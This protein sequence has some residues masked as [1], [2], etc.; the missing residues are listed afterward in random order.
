MKFR[1][2]LIGIA[3]MCLGLASLPSAQEDPRVAD[4]ADT[5]VWEPVPVVVTPGTGAAPPSDAIVLFDGSDLNRWQHRD[6]SDVRWS[7]ADGAVTVMPGS[8][9]ILTRDAFGDVQL[10][11]EWRTP[12]KIEG[13]GQERGNSG[14][15][16][17]QRYEVQILDSHEN[18]T[19]SN[20][21][22]ASIYKQ[23]SPLVNASRL[24]GEW[25]SYDIFFTAPRFAANGNVAT[26]AYVT[27]L[28][29]GVLV[30]TNVE[31]AG[32]VRHIGEPCYQP[33][34][35]KQPLQLQNHQ[36]LVSF[37]NIWIREL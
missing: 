31:I 15:F 13:E 27:V 32:P 6:G 10:H 28:H 18:R 26:P 20:G 21:Q 14:I 30:Q 16:I 23:H 5:E 9:D 17:Q 36:N 11:L 3:A 1:Y 35:L 22:A 29:N 8:G 33:H 37:R 4:P 25:Q 24:P 19:Y 2:F 7:L 34:P 12:K